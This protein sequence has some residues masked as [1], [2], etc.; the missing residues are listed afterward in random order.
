MLPD[1]GGV[2]GIGV[3]G[4]MSPTFGACGVQMGAKQYQTRVK[5][6]D[7]IINSASFTTN[8]V[9][10]YRSS[11]LVEQVRLIVYCLLPSLF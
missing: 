1:M 6:F 10:R 11:L 7:E 8:V 9:I 2:T 4:T 3:W 5:H